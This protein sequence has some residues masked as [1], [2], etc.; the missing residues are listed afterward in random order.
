[1]T[2]EFHFSAH[3][4]VQDR[5]DVAEFIL[6]GARSVQ[7]HSVFMLKGF[8]VIE[9]MKRGFMDRKGFANVEA[10]QGVIVPKLLTFDEMLALYPETKGKIIAQVD[11]FLCNGCGTCE[12]I[13]A[14][15][16][17]RLTDGLALVDRDLCEGCRLCVLLCPNS[18]VELLNVFLM[19]KKRVG[20]H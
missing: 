10:M 8:K 7:A 19:R 6:Y 11:E 1:M 18:A 12:E 14:F 15:D 4:G 16:S 3:G 2:R 17:I 5:K 20:I 13:C 9:E